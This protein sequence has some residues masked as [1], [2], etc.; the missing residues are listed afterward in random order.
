M[1]HEDFVYTAVF[2]PNGERVVTASKD[3][4]ARLWDAR[5]GEAIRVPMRQMEHGAAVLA[6][7]FD[8]RGER[9][10][11]ASDD[12]TARIWSVPPTGQVLVDQVRARLGRNAPEPLKISSTTESRRGFVGAIAAGFGAIW[13]R[14]TPALSFQH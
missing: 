8:P 1:G 12:A 9:I 11:T 3:N 4:Y 2:D 5:T 10:V 13:T 14:I 6:A 7:A